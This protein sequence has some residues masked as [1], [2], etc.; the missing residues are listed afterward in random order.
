MTR[1]SFINELDWKLL[2]EKYKGKK[3]KRIVKKIENNYPVQYAIG[4]VEFL[5]CN[6]IVNSSVLVPRFETELLVD[7]LKK[8]IIKYNMRSSE[9][10]DLCTGSGCIGISLKK[11]FTS[12]SVTCLDKSYRALR[13]A[14][15]NAKRNNVSIT[16]KRCDILKQ[17]IKGKYSIL[18]S[19]PPYLVKGDYVT[20]NTKAEPSMALYTKNSDI[21]FYIRI[22][23]ISKELLY[24]SNIIAFEIGANQSERICSYVKTIYPD[25]KI[26]VEKDYNELERYIFIF[27]NIE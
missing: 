7:K 27:N 19:N 8:Y 12:S 23:D 21:E 22:L 14:K 2:I 15:K 18:V 9:I 17:V 16:L 5:N 3:L 1:P 13:T 6:I 20:P 4:N 25:A 26:I 24:S 11:V 10:L